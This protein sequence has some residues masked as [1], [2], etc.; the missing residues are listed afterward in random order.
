MVEGQLEWGRAGVQAS[1][2]V[3]AVVLAP[4]RL[5]ILCLHSLILPLLADIY[6]LLLIYT[7]FLRI[8]C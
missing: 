4:V 1:G 8:P 3:W 5:S 6:A 2:P 7:V